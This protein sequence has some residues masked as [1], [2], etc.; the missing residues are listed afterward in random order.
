MSDK[1]QKKMSY[2]L[3]EDKAIQQIIEAHQLRTRAE[4]LLKDYLCG[5]TVLKYRDEAI[6]LLAE[7][8]TNSN[9]YA[10]TMENF[11]FSDNRIK[12]KKT[13]ENVIVIQ[14]KDFQIITSYL[15]MTAA[16]ENDLELLGI[17]MRTH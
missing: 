8:Y 1:Q 9:F 2:A 11:I 6:R 4:Y 14:Q 16:C 10:E 5:D 7:Y 15:A 17:S 12:D 3:N 13:G